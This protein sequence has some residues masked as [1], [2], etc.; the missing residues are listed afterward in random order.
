[1]FILTFFQL[2]FWQHIFFS[3]ELL[4]R[5]TVYFKT[6]INAY[7]LTSNAQTIPR[8]QRWR[9]YNHKHEFKNRDLEVIRF[10][11]NLSPIYRIVSLFLYRKTNIVEVLYFHVVVTN[12]I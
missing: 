11:A 1:M 4:V 2:N 12:E 10:I 7:W 3:L 6:P 9:W 5:F 8:K